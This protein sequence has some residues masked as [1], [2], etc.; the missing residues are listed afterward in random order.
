[1][2]LAS[3]LTS[4]SP[5]VQNTKQKSP[6][7]IDQQSCSENEF[8]QGK[9]HE[10]TLSYTMTTHIHQDTSE[11][12]EYHDTLSNGPTSPVHISKR[13]SSNSI[14]SPVRFH[15]PLQRPPLD[16]SR[17]SAVSPSS[18]STIRFDEGLTQTIEQP[19][20]DDAEGEENT[21]HRADEGMSTIMHDKPASHG[22]DRGEET[23]ITLSIDDTANDISTFSA[24]PDADLTRFA[25]LR[26]SAASPTRRDVGAWSP[27]KQLGAGTPG[28]V[29]RPLQLPNRSQSDQNF[30]NDTTPRRP[31]STSS[32]EDL[33]SFTGQSN[34]FMPPPQSSSRASIRR[35]FSG[36]AGFPIRINPSPTHR[37]QASVDRERCRGVISPA[38]ETVSTPFSDRRTNLLDFDLEPLATPRSIPSITPRELESL[39]SELSSQIASLSATLSG[40]EA[41]VLALKRAITDAE[42]RV[43]NTSEELRNEKSHRE[44]LEQEKEDWD[45]RGRDMESVLR[46][47]RQEIMVGEHER[48]KLRKQTEEAEKRT[49]EMEVR[50]VELQ[51]R[52][53]SA[54]RRTTISPTSSP[55][56]GDG[57][58]GGPATPAVDGDGMG[59]MDI[60]EAVREATERVARDLHSLYKSKHETKVAALKK[61]YEARWEKKVRHLEDELKSATTEIVNLKTERDATMTGP[62]ASSATA[63]QQQQQQQQQ[64]QLEDQRRVSESLAK[65]NE[66]IG[67]E[68]KMLSAKVEGLESELHS[69]RQQTETLREEFE[70]ERVEKGELVAQVDLFLAMGEAEPTPPLNTNGLA[71]EPR[72]RSVSSDSVP[73]SS[74]ST[75]RNMDYHPPQQQ[76]QSPARPATNGARGGGLPT[77]RPRPIS[78]L[79]PPGKFSGIPGPGARG[80]VKALPTRA[81]GGGGGGGIM[82]GIA[83]MGAGTRGY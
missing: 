73:T 75:A 46:E 50:V 24:I 4:L 28:T 57:T 56:K 35:S 33:L 45:R 43:G 5:S 9:A 2:A 66:Q 22:Q 52:L 44:G 30:E 19:V 41:E 6:L 27:S 32:P 20:T 39:R 64:Q 65:Q 25:A 60:N 67:A 70:R 48:D 63:D 78:M 31:L 68:N 71:A 59:A 36:R 61:S 77:G 37:S 79:Q 55:K 12:D 26:D 18:E 69:V 29:K 83:K 49:E 34:I 74:F 13:L 51:T 72:L 11:D 42:V 1:M 47:I 82:E 81:G 54:N 17:R 40:K 15:S 38:K 14:P 10:K 53:A 7:R 3:P 80:P 8:D 62:L 58:L 23:E 21:M 16:E 76:P